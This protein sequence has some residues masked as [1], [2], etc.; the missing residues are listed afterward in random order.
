MPSNAFTVTL[1][2]KNIDTVFST[3]KDPAEVRRSLINHD[4]YDPGIIVTR[5]RKRKRVGGWSGSPPKAAGPTDSKPAPVFRSWLW[6]DHSISKA[7]SRQLR[8][9]HNA[10]VNAYAALVK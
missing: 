2:R 8:E 5:Q 10:L 7:E 6:P 4:G 9:E 1:N 3:E